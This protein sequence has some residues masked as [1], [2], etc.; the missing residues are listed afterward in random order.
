MH[1]KTVYLAGQVGLM[2]LP[3]ICMLA[4][5]PYPSTAAECMH[6]VG[7]HWM[8]LGYALCEHLQ[9]C[10]SMHAAKRIVKQMCCSSAY[11]SIVL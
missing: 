6:L 10:A 4:C 8:F 11:V 1:N 7:L 9:A 3:Q 2:L 5:R